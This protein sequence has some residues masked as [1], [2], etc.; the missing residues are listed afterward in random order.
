MGE[1]DKKIAKFLKTSSELEQYLHDDGSLTPLQH[2]TIETT[3]QGLHT[4]LDSWTR[5]HWPDHMPS[6]LSQ[7]TSRKVEGL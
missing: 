6:F 4:L 3:I 5:K 1:T 7:I 2:Q